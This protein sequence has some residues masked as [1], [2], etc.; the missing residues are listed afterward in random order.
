MRIMTDEDREDLED[1]EDRRC[2][3]DT[4]VLLRIMNP[5]LP[6]NTVCNEAMV[7]LRRSNY[8][9]FFTIQNAT[10]FW[11]VSTRPTERNGHGLTNYAT[12]IA[13][14]FIEEIAILL[15][16]DARVYAQWRRLVTEHAIRGVQV[17]DAR[18][19]A[20][21]IVHGVRHI[22][23]LNARDFMRFSDVE[24]IHP[25]TLLQ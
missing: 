21:M 20:S 16:D 12:G 6:E 10:E 23:T 22:L 15:P 17:H 24:A 25:A 9:L 14:G 2:L 5:H 13:L 3:L 11:N 18:L 19:A 1:R 8:S 4:N 7:R